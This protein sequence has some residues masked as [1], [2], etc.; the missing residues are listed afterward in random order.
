MEFKMI[1]KLT[2]EELVI[3][4]E[5]YIESD[6]GLGFKPP[7]PVEKYDISFHNYSEKVYLSSIEIEAI[8]EEEKK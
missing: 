4:I 1:F 8:R 5:H 2:K 3:A 7:Y 6:T